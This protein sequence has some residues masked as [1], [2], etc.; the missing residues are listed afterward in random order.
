M[1]T[2]AV[3]QIATGVRRI[4]SADEQ[5]DRATW[6]ALDAI[7]DLNRIANDALTSRETLAIHS[8]LQ[9]VQNALFATLH[10]CGT[11]TND[12]QEQDR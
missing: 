6:V 9:E 8:R 4:P 1:R 10:I 11:R 3:I 5:I 7:G 12:L 2:A